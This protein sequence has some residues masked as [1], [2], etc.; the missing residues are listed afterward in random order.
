M[1]IVPPQYKKPHDVT[2]S[3]DG[4]SE[5]AKLV[6]SPRSKRPKRLTRGLERVT[7]LFKKQ[8]GKCYLCGAEMKLPID[9]SERNVRDPL[10][11]TIDH[12]IPRSLGGSNKKENIKAAHAECNK[13]KRNT[14]PQST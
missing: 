3:T 2:S 10:E 9:F 13:R 11:A 5:M 4:S 14:L 7:K 8:E 6:D 1:S 12:V